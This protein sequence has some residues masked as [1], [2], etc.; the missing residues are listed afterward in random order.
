MSRRK[1]SMSELYVSNPRHIR[2]SAQ[3]YCSIKPPCPSGMSKY[4][5]KKSRS[6]CCR[7]H[8]RHRIGPQ[9][10]WPQFRHKEA[11]MEKKTGKHLS[12]KKISSLYRKLKTGHQLKRFIGPLKST[13]TRSR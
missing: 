1:P 3:K 8:W 9:N 7:A 13:K 4:K 2:F 12:R 5:M 10:I 11:L 6:H